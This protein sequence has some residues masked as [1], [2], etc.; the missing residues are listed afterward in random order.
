MESNFQI[1]TTTRE[2]WD[3]M[4]G[5]IERANTSIYWELYIFA[6]DA[7]G[8]RF[9]DLLEEKARQGLDVKLIIDALGS[10]GLSKKR[11]QSLR[12]AGVDLVFFSQ[13]H[14]YMGWWKQL[15][16]RTHRKILV[17]DE[18]VGFIGGVNIQ[19]GMEEWMD[20]QVRI[21]GKPVH[22][23]LRAFAKIYMISG[24]N[25]DEVKHLLK[26][27]FRVEKVMSDIEF[28]YDEPHEGRSAIRKRYTEA[29]LKARERVIL[30]SPYYFPDKKFLQAL[31]SARKRNVHVDLLIP[32]RTD[33]RIATYAAYTW[34]SLM[35]LY[36]VH[37]YLIKR[38]MH[39]KGVIM[40]DEWAMIGSSNIDSMSFYDNYEANIK[41]TDKSA[42]K[43]LKD[44]VLEW[45]SQA[46][47]LE[48][49]KWE[50][51][52]RM[53]RL[54]EWIALKLYRIWHQDR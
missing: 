43:R 19:K 36:G 7:A 52:G 6:D 20:I 11:V 37:V 30:F 9:F 41:I 34:F 5:A 29:L 33:V 48:E 13:K 8:T 51:R 49:S 2:S 31:W 39:G 47:Q 21:E 35:K 16:T 45:L 10:F 17:I 53:Q 28:I 18:S 44:T 23:L 15:W 4:Y 50:K 54:K 12:A 24:G 14:R 3:A 40:D 25:R 42:V 27:K 32:F 46:V 1:Y 26:Y 22:S 38:M